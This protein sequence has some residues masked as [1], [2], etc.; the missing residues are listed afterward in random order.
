MR[1]FDELEYLLAFDFSQMRALGNRATDEGLRTLYSTLMNFFE[2]FH[3][4]PTPTLDELNIYHI[5]MQQILR[6]IN[7]AEYQ[8]FLNKYRH[9][10]PENSEEMHER[11]AQHC[12]LTSYEKL[13]G[14]FEYW[15]ATG[16]YSG[17]IRLKRE[18][19]WISTQ[20]R[21]WNQM[22]KNAEQQEEQLERSFLNLQTN[23]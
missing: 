4:G 21:T 1:T 12:R 3:E 10:Y 5:Y 23:N 20:M 16:D 14:H 2:S 17:S 7:Q 6:C 9:E 11:M 13:P 22:F 18:H 15:S 19:K 8:Y